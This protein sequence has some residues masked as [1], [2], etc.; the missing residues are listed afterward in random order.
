MAWN[1]RS[2]SFSIESIQCVEFLSPWCFGSSC[3]VTDWV[4]KLSLFSI[5]T[6]SSLQMKRILTEWLLTFMSCKRLSDARTLVICF[7]VVFSKANNRT[8]LLNFAAWF[9]LLCRFSLSRFTMRLQSNTSFA[10]PG[11]ILEHLEGRKPFCDHCAKTFYALDVQEEKFQTIPI[12]FS[13]NNVIYC[14][15]AA[16]NQSKY[17]PK[18]QTLRQL[19]VVRD[20]SVHWA[21][22]FA[23]H[24]G[25]IRREHCTHFCTKHLTVVYCL[26]WW[27]EL[28]LKQIVL[29][30]RSHPTVAKS[31]KTF[32]FQIS[33][34]ESS[35]IN[36]YFATLFFSESMK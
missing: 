5:E 17:D 30:L 33:S 22:W 35:K 12:H 3:F 36:K 16:T 24:H 34:Q 32:R 15:Y 27:N 23:S 28:C 18:K 14:L 8:L 29:S 25:E 10:F 20:P 11:K 26:L 7:Q 2:F 19:A 21:Y 6:L 4:I 1:S 13:F 9:V 31:T